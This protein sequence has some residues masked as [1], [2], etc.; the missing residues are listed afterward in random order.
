MAN[1][2][3]QSISWKSGGGIHWSPMFTMLVDTAQTVDDING[4]SHVHS[5]LPLKRDFNF[6]EKLEG[7]CLS[8]IFEIFTSFFAFQNKLAFYCAGT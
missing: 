8:I 5:F 2:I 7:Y 4:A 6:D 3:K 1:N